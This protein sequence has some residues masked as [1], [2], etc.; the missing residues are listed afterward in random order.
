LLDEKT[1]SGDSEW[2][3]TAEARVNPVSGLGGK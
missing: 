2:M 1:R 3:E